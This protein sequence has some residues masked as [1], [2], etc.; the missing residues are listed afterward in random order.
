LDAVDHEF[1]L[2]AASVERTARVQQ[3]EVERFF[4]TAPRRRVA[5]TPSAPAKSEGDGSPDDIPVD[6]VGPRRGAVLA[7]HLSAA[8]DAVVA[9][10]EQRRT[11]YDDLPDED[12]KRG[13]VTEMRQFVA[14]AR[15]LHRYLS[16]LDAASDPPLDLGTRYLVDQLAARLVASE[17]ELTV[18]AGERSYGKVTNPLAPVFA[19]SGAGAPPEELAIVVFVPRRE[20][21]SG[22][23]HPL[24]IHELAHAA[25]DRH[26]LVAEVLKAATEDKEFMAAMTSAAQ[27]QSKA[28]GQ[29]EAA[30]IQ[31]IG[32]RI[33]AWV[34]EA[35]CDAVAT[36]LLGPTYLY[37]F[38]A[39]VGTSDLDRAG[40]EHPP[41]RQRIGLLLSQLD[42]LGWA[43]LMAEASGE[44]LE[45][46]RQTA[47]HQHAYDD[48]EEQF[49]VAALGRLA[50]SIHR[51]AA[52]HVDGLSFK[53]EN[54][55]PV[56]T[57]VQELLRAGIPPSQAL[58]RSRIDRAAII[59]GSWLFAIEREGSDLAALAQAPGVDELAR[60]LPKALQD[61]ALLE[62]WEEH[63]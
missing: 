54:F 44:I 6:D 35:I 52:S 33:A 1:A 10:V 58:D 26:Q 8:Y 43:D 63:A 17:A 53:A 51:V 40:D 57:E 62:A 32:V 34:E 38:M 50:E 36:Q 46:F 37:A 56:Q 13:A 59:L 18:V 11:D 61:A 27:A 7:R 19:L 45:W 30:I 47:E 24:L 5:E 16:W 39:I 9:H 14:G 31:G 22:L 3:G 12:A 48:P 28:T 41:T 29:D 4:K 23:L 21:R 2:L 15:S 20:Q 60:L 55:T 49:C 25:D 42:A